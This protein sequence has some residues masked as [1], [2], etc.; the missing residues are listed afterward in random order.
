MKKYNYLL[1]IFCV[2][3]FS[4]GSFAEMEFGNRNS[5]NDFQLNITDIM[6]AEEKLLRSIKCVDSRNKQKQEVQRNKKSV[7]I[8]KTDKAYWVSHHEISAGKSSV[9]FYK[10]GSGVAYN[11]YSVDQNGIK[12]PVVEGQLL[13]MQSKENNAITGRTV[14]V[15]QQINGISWLSC[16]KAADKAIEKSSTEASINAKQ[17]STL[18][19]KLAKF[20]RDQVE[21][22]KSDCKLI[23]SEPAGR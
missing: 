14:P 15:T 9:K 16:G 20:F 4:Q 5:I 19:G 7:N 10:E 3:S 21:S 23:L 11:V 6:E 22:C 17:P 2:F 1:A 12:R 8:S 13:D 18:I